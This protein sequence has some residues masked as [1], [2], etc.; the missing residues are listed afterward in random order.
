MPEKPAIPAEVAVEMVSVVGDMNEEAT[1]I[2]GEVA[3]AVAQLQ[4]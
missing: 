3:V 2:P 4:Y 1:V